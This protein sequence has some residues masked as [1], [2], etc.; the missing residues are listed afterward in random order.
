M[1]TEKVTHLLHTDRELSK[2]A[3]DLA[4]AVNDPQEF[5]R[6]VILFEDLITSILK[7]GYYIDETYDDENNNYVSSSSI[8]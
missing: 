8:L 2:L 7:S 5:D 6:L 3:S 4:R 1:E